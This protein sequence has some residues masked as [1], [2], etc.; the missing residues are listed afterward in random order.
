[1]RLLSLSVGVLLGLS[2]CARLLPAPEPMARVVHESP[3]APRCVLLLLPGRGDHADDFDRHGFTGLVTQRGLKV[4]TVAADATMGYYY[5]GTMAQRV[6]EDVVAPLRRQYPNAELWVS[7]MSMGGLGSVLFAMEHP[8]EV[9][10]MFLMAP[11]LGDGTV[12]KEVRAQGGLKTWAAPAAAPRTA[13]NFDRQVWR[14]LKEVTSGAAGMPSV[15]LGYGLK[16]G[17]AE[18]D[19]TLG[20]ALPT[21]RVWLAPGGHDWPY[22]QPIFERFLDSDEFRARCG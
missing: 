8:N 5:R 2:G 3:T 16:D 19:G 7:G 12:A 11:Y 18:D 22:W 17:L 10:G 9:S 15:Y 6:T 20:A 1:M 13:D 14:Y 4:V 21:E